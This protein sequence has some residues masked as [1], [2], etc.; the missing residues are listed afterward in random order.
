[1]GEQTFQSGKWTGFYVYSK[2]RS[3]R[4][5]MDMNLSFHNGVVDGTGQDDIGRFTIGGKFDGNKDEC[6]WTKQYLGQHS[7]Y[8]R[9]FGDDLQKAIWGTWE[10]DTRWRGGF[11]IWPVAGGAGDGETETKKQE[12][13]I[14]VCVWER[15]D[16]MP[17]V[18]P[19]KRSK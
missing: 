18:I 5:R 1:M 3:R 9:G 7:V 2:Q 11:K 12:Q 10:I 17:T 15:I 16:D 6:W 13:P 19:A 4:H 14:T 8:Y